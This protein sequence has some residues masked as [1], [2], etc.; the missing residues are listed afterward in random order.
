[1]ANYAIEAHTTSERR[2][3]QLAA[4]S[5]SGHK[6][7]RKKSNDHEI[8]VKLAQIAEDHPRWG[9]RKMAA[10]LK[11]QGNQWNHKTHLL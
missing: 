3:C 8:K 4:L 10:Y 1:M 9:F 5:R 11:K 2:A 7:V 6:Y